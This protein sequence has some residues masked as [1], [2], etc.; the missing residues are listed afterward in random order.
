MLHHGHASD[1]AGIT[2][3][4]DGALNG[5]VLPRYAQQELMELREIAHNPFLQMVA[6]GNVL[7]MN[8]G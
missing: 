3:L 7:G 1:A 2:E 5:V 8:M 4:S 6:E